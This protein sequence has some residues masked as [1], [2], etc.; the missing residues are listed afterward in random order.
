M[1]YTSLSSKAGNHPYQPQHRPTPMETPWIPMGTM[2][3][4]LMLVWAEKLGGTCDGWHRSLHDK[5]D[6]NHYDIAF[7]AVVKTLNRASLQ[8][9]YLL[10]REH[11]Q[12]H[13]KRRS[14]SRYL[15]WFPTIG[16]ILC[17]GFRETH[18]R[19]PVSWATTPSTRPIIALSVTSKF[20]MKTSD[21]TYYGFENHQ[22]RTFPQMTK[23]LGLVIY[24]NGN[25]EEKIGEGVH[26]KNVFG[27]YFHGPILSL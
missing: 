12:L 3:T 15:R 21:E 18:R 5:F 6:E 23:P 1:V 10:K 8:T 2:E 16:A 24:G 22:G 27:S 26:Y 4:S 17:W 20:T 11:W 14:S 25:N 7:S 9:T 13:P 19:A